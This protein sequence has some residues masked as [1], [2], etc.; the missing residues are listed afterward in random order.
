MS[1]PSFLFYKKYFKFPIHM[2]ILVVLGHIKPISIFAQMTADNLCR[3]G[4][5]SLCSGVL[6]TSFFLLEMC[7]LETFLNFFLK[8]FLKEGR[9]FKT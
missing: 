9:S 4:P 7:S 8:Y 2:W 3:V 1:L 5:M 6:K